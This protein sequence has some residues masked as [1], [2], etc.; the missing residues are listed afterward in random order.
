M[1]APGNVGR[2]QFTG[3]MWLPDL[4]LYHYKA[5]IY[6]PALG[7]FMQIDPI[8]YEQ[9]MNLYQYAFND[10]LLL[11]DSTGEF[12]HIFAGA[13]IGAIAGGAFEAGLIAASVAGGGSFAG[14]SAVASQIATAAA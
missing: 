12:A 4:G 3:Q 1:P 11:V 7:R 14:W 5:R 6:D 13:A 10:P 9:S 8:G 2:F